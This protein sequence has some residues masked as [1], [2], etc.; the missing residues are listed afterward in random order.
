[1][2]ALVRQSFSNYRPGVPD[3]TYSIISC[4]RT[5]NSTVVI[6]VYT[7]QLPKITSIHSWKENSSSRVKIEIGRFDWKRHDDVTFI[8]SFDSSFETKLSYRYILWTTFTNRE[9]RIDEYDA[10]IER[11]A[12]LILSFAPCC[13]KLKYVV[14]IFIRLFHQGFFTFLLLYCRYC[15]WNKRNE[16][17]FR[18]DEEMVFA[19]IFPEVRR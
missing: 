5:N 14:T 4:D 11:S 7:L 6:P 10:I 13:S 12:A 1:M 15:R 18:G 2:L 3:R 8:P 19:K 17:L 16:K 9:S